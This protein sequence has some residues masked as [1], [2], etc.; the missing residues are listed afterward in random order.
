MSSKNAVPDAW[1]DDWTKT[2]KPSETVI[3]PPPPKLTKTE[4]HMETV[5]IENSDAPKSDFILDPRKDIPLTSDLRPSVKKVLSRKPTR[6]AG[7]A[8]GLN[9]GLTLEDDDDDEDEEGATK[10]ETVE[11]RKAR[12]DSEREEKLKRYN[13][14][15][16]ELLGN[17]GASVTGS[18][19]PRSVTPPRNRSVIDFRGRGRNDRGQESRPSSSRESKGR[20]LFDPSYSAKP[21]STYLQKREGQSSGTSNPGEEVLMQPMRAPR[22]PDGT[23][24]FTMM[25]R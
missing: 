13:E 19:S 6:P 5:L 8:N 25:N 17:P 14:R 23:F 11:E 20:Q 4:K 10:A 12:A 2:P 15:R 9:S 7:P 1:D 21:D 3:P 18:N 24:G 16:R 22:G